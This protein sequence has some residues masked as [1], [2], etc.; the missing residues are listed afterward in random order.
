MR[1]LRT[2]LVLSHVLPVLVAVPLLGLL[3][4]II[5]ATQGLLAGAEETLARQQEQL[6]EQA[7]AMEG[8]KGAVL[9]AV[10]AADGE[11]LATHKLSFPPVWDG[12]AAAGGRL[13]LATMDGK[14]ICLVG[15]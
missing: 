13:Y 2:R 6:A 11:T 5:L 10:A 7:A 4:Y 12:M 14:V 9:L 8:R 3:G 1:S 15:K